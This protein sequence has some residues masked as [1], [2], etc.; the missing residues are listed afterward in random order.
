MDQDTTFVLTAAFVSR[1][2]IFIIGCLFGT[3]I[4]GKFSSQG[5]LFSSS[6]GKCIIK[7][8]SHQILILHLY[9]PTSPSILST[10]WFVDRSRILP[11]GYGCFCRWMFIISRTNSP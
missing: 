4:A 2:G 6:F 8:I 11:N 1:I 10:P 7:L 9:N 5:T 3:L